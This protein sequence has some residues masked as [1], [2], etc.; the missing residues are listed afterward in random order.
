MINTTMASGHKCYKKIRMASEKHGYH[1]SINSVEKS[2]AAKHP[3]MKRLKEE[4][5]YIESGKLLRSFPESN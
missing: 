1:R 5:S 2:K 3:Y 4:F